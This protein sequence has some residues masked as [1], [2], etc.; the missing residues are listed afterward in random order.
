[1]ANSVKLTSATECLTLQT[2]WRT[3]RYRYNR[4]RICVCVCVCVCVL[5]YFQKTSYKIPHAAIWDHLNT[6]VEG[7]YF[8]KRKND[9]TFWRCRVRQTSCKT[10]LYITNSPA[11]L[12]STPRSQFPF[13][14]RAILLSASFNRRPHLLKQP[15]D[16]FSLIKYGITALYFSSYSSFFPFIFYV[17]LINLSINDTI[18]F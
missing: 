11:S 12:F 8:R 7:K 6:W 15:S 10:S 13:L 5:K 14:Y 18:P 3:N 2:R 9:V 16:K 4:F 17:L 1:M